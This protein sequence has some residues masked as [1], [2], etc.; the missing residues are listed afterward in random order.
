VIVLAADMV[1][2]RVL[3]FLVSHDYRVDAIF[4]DPS[5][6]GGYNDQIAALISRAPNNIELM[7]GT[8]LERPEALD[9]LSAMQPHLGVLAWW[10]HLLKGPIVTLPKLGWLNLHPSLLPHNRGKYPNFWCVADA[11]PC[12]V[13][14]HFIDAG[15]D[16]GPV[17]AQSKLEVGWEDTGESIYIRSREEIVELFEKSIEGVL[18][19]RLAPV[20]QE[21]SAGVLHHSSAIGPG[22]TLDLDAPTTARRVLNVIRAKMFQPH[23]AAKFIDGGKTYSV[24]VMIREVPNDD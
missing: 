1:G 10:P 5:D 24:E 22:S 18:S 14:L 21:H 8:E 2:F 12:G 23:A 13:S 16:S 7:N 17:V 15:V 3:Q 20:G 6:P 4:V 9:R 11:T 19:G